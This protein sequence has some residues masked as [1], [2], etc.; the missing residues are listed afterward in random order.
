MLIHKSI[1][2]YYY[3]WIYSYF[4]WYMHIDYDVMKFLNCI[5]NMAE[6]QC[7][8]SYLSLWQTLVY[9]HYA[10]RLQHTAPEMSQKIRYH[11][12]LYTD[13]K[14]FTNET[15]FHQQMKWIFVKKCL[16]IIFISFFSILF[17]LKW[18]TSFCWNALKSINIAPT[19][20]NIFHSCIKHTHRLYLVYNKGYLTN[21][22]YLNIVFDNYKMILF[23]NY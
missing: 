12:N 23:Q 20:H 17:W 16:C 5:F 22:K 13:L 3:T 19:Q 6:K 18:F 14:I 11:S 2:K 8:R 7:Q 15:L 10:R 9:R 4:N 21:I 1:K